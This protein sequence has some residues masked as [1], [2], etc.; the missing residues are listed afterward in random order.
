MVFNSENVTID[1]LMADIEYRETTR[2]LWESIEREIWEPDL[3]IPVLLL[4]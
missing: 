4:D 1:K 2:K 3:E